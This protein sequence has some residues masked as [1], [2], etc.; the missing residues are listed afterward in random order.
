MIWK[1]KCSVEKDGEW[2][3]SYCEDLGIA[4]QGETVQEAKKNLE[5]AVEMFFED[6]SPI[7]ILNHLG[8]LEAESPLEIRRAP[9]Q[10]TQA[11]E[12]ELVVA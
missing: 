5:E 10:E 4:S 11:T 6:A 1:L 12:W 2:Y 7:E 8:L 9:H 3:A